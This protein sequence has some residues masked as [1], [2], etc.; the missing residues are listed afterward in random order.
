MEK[1]ETLNW[2]NRIL[3]SKFSGWQN[4][5]IRENQVD[6]SKCYIYFSSNDLYIKDSESDFKKKIVENDRYEWLNRRTKEIPRMEI[7]IRDIWLSW[8]VNGIN[9]EL[10]S[11]DKL[12]D[13]LKEATQ[14]LEITTVGVSSGGYEASIVA[15]KLGAARCFDFSGQFS[16]IHH[17]N[18]VKTNPFLKRY[19]SEYPDGGNLE[20]Y[21]IIDGADTVIYYFLP[22]KSAQD[23]EQAKYAAKCGNVRCIRFSS[24][25]HG[26][27]VL[28]IS[29][30]ELLSWDNNKLDG[31]FDRSEKHELNTIC[32]SMRVSGVLRTFWFLSKKAFGIRRSSLD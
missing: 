18:H 14:G 2:E 17:F 7:F 6:N 32:F 31:L 3:Q 24:K 13:Y 28:S 5:K 25:R 10:N 16:L 23:I 19:Y 27:P 30:P 15:A 20:V 22:M 1:F 4:V 9:G 29:L 21:R 11:F 12:I 26:S 8:Y